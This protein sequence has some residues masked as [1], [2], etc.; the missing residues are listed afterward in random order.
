M[1]IAGHDPPADIYV[2]DNKYVHEKKEKVQQS[3]SDRMGRVQA[4]EIHSQGLQLHMQ[5][6]TSAYQ[7]C[8]HASKPLFVEQLECI[9]TH[10]LVSTDPCQTMHLWQE[11]VQFFCVNALLR[12]SDVNVV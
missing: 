5:R 2:D 4:R 9:C 1:A 10:L 3:A 6:N 12:G 11:A 8:T 7:T